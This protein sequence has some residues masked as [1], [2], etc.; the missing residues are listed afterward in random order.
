MGNV[1][2]ASIVNYDSYCSK[3]GEEVDS[4]YIVVRPALTTK[5][6]YLLQE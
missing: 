1:E 4:K 6:V 3:V 5:H 2:A